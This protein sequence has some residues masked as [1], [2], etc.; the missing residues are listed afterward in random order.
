MPVRYS[1]SSASL[2]PSL[3]RFTGQ[4]GRYVP[5][6]ETIEGFKEILS[7]KCDDMPEQAF[8]MVGNIEEAYEKAKTLKGE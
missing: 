4:K 5:L 1:V 2:S 6:K 3:N 8:Y 7:G